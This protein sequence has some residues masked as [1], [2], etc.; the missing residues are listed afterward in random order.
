MLYSVYLHEEIDRTWEASLRSRVR[1]EARDFFF[2][3][4]IRESEETISSNKF[5]LR[6]KKS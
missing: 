3:K 5:I 6:A 2:L 1:R 4:K